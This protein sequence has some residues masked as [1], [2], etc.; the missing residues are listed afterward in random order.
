M[1]NKKKK[2]N[3]LLANVSGLISYCPLCNSSFHPRN[4]SIIS[5]GD[6]I[7]LL[8]ATCQYCSSAAVILLVVG[9]IG[10]RSVGLVTDLTQQDICRF[11]HSDYVSSDDVIGLHG[12]FNV[13]NRIFDLI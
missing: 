9:D 11:S 10:V 5:E 1:E 4:V 7:Q 6:N 3:E 2:Q 12:I 8:H 13:E